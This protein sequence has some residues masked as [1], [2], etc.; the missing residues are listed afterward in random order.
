[1]K[2]IDSLTRPQFSWFDLVFVV[3]TF[4]LIRDAQ[5]PQALQTLGFMVIGAVIATEHVWLRPAIARRR[6]RQEGGGTP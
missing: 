5:L 6:L 4:T 1:M 3:I 2:I